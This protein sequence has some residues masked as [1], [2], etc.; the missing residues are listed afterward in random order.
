MQFRS[1]MWANNYNMLYKYMYGKCMHQ[2]KIKKELKEN[3]YF[4]NK[5][6]IPPWFVGY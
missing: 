6:V 2:L 5:T 4:F 3:F 1:G